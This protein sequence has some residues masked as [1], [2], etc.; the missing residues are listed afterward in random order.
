MAFTEFPLPV[1]GV[2]YGLPVDKT[3][4]TSSGYM[5]NVRPVDTLESRVRLGQRPGFDKWSATQVSGGVADAIVSM[6]VV[7]VID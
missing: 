6:S 3:P 4:P 1:M 5:S 7:T 2:N